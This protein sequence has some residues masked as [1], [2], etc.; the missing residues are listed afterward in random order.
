MGKERQT[1][2]NINY[3]V[4]TVDVEK[5]NTILLRASQVTD[6]LRTA[7][8]NFGNSAGK[9]FQSA[10]KYI[11]GMEIEL[12]RL[13][14]QIK[15]TNT[16]DV[17]RLSQLSNQYK[18]LKS[19]IDAYN[20]ALFDTSTATKAAAKSSQNLASQFG[21]VFTAVK[22]FIAAGIVREIVSMSLD[23]ARLAG[24]VEG[25][26]RAFARAFPNS[27]HLLNELRTATHGTITDFE[28]M[29]RTL[30]ASNLGISV[31][32]LGVL[33]EFAAV[34]A[35]Q[36]GESVDYLVESIVTGIGRKSILKLDNLG[37]SATR[38]K[39]QFGGAAIASKSV[40]EVTEGVAAIAK[41]ELEKM[42]GY[43]ET[44]ATKV[45]QI[46]RRWTELKTTLAKKQ[47]A[48]SLN[49]F[50]D[51][52][53]VGLEAGVK[54]TEQLIDERNKLTAANKVAAIIES[55]AY[56]NLKDN[57]VAKI[58]LLFQEL[59][60]TK[61]ILKIREQEIETIRQ[62]RQELINDPLVFN[63]RAALKP[64]DEQLKSMKSSRD[65]LK[66]TLSILKK[67]VVE[68]RK[69]GEVP[70]AEDGGIVNDK[71]KQIKDLQEALDKTKDRSDLGESG[72]LV[73]AIKKA[74]DE[75]D[76]LLGKAKTTGNEIREFLGYL[77]D[78]S[79]FQDK[80]MLSDRTES[81]KRLQKVE[82]D[83]NKRSF[84]LWK[85][86]QELRAQKKKEYE[87]EEIAIAEDAAKKKRA[88]DQATAQLAEEFLRDSLQFL[89]TQRSIDTEDLRNYYDD[90]INLAGDN[91][92]A[93]KDIEV[94]RDRE[95]AKAE[96]RAKDREKEN[97]KKKIAID[98]LVAIAKIFAEWGWPEGVFPA[99]IMAGITAVNISQ[100]DRYREGGWIKGPGTETSDSVPI[101]ASKN[102]FMVNAAN[103]KKSPKLLEQVNSGKLND[104]MLKDIMSGRSGGSSLAAVDLTPV[105]NGLKDLKNAQPDLV[106]RANTVYEGR[107]RGDRYR[108]WVRSKSM[109]A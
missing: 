15:L 6:Q 55:D 107:K 54:G 4:N 13:R 42:G 38:L 70:E 52:L 74:Q 21:Q 8:Q 84:E 37:L 29:Q 47:D 40:G 73:L 9:S 14:Q 46:E 75:L 39:E 99:A 45:A 25:V 3:K 91:A 56:K 11:E 60:A 49:E 88:L 65:V 92:R 101:L 48:S 51:F 85:Y 12:A 67:Y 81:N 19:Q 63:L 27:V 44:A 76:V 82:T 87:D 26:E 41:V 43:A 64:L 28:L 50:W 103:A 98:G 69:T 20:K 1:N 2:V 78:L 22:A 32:H 95:L 89:F 57:E 23:M 7:T 83:N 58:D 10:S 5:G 109:N 30:Q 86:W 96:E 36:T 105:V 90:Q 100:A 68:L 62:R 72:K 35:Q 59:I 77:S 18:S 97:A 104:R 31:D 80:Q 24:N 102:E 106:L 93:K 17:A 53:L 61:N 94:K 33:L 16:Q 34:R 71:R 66:E 79:M 108:Q